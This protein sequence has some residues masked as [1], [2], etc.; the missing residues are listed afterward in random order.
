MAGTET[1]D[2]FQGTVRHVGSCWTGTQ[3]KTKE[4]NKELC[5]QI[6]RG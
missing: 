3:F 2:T 4:K 5:T 6:A 1:R